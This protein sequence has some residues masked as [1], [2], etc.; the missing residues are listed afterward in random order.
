MH[1]LA[2]A[3]INY[4]RYVSGSVYQAINRQET[5]STTPSTSFDAADGKE[6]AQKAEKWAREECDTVRSEPYVTSASVAGLDVTPGSA[7]G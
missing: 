3:R 2:T 6:A 5:F 7:F 1:Y 4:T